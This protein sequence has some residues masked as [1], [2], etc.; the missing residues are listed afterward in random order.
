MS[1][2][3]PGYRGKLRCKK[4]KD[5]RNDIAHH[6]ARYPGVEAAEMHYVWQ[7]AYW[8]F[9]LCLLR[10]AEAPQACFD[11]LVQSQRFLFEAE[12]IRRFL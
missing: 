11:R 6:L 5:Y 1:G 9:V 7:A 3:T 10:E 4:A 12:E 2:R 8:L